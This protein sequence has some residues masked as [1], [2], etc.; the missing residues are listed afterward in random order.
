MKFRGFAF[1]GAAFI[2]LGAIWAV[3]AVS[4]STPSTTSVLTIKVKSTA[5]NPGD[6][7]VQDTSGNVLATCQGPSSPGTSK[8]KVDVT[9]GEGILLVAQPVTAGTFMHWT[10]ACSSVPGP[11]CHEAVTQ[12]LTAVGHFTSTSSTPSAVTT[13]T[14]VEGDTTGCSGFN[15]GV[16]VNGTGFPATTSVTLSD[17]GLQVASGTTDGS[18]SAQ[19]SFTANSESGI[20]RTLVMAT[21]GSAATTDIYNEGSYCLDQQNGTGT[22][23]VS[24]EVVATDLDANGSGTIRFANKPLLP[25]Q[26]NASGTYTVTTPGYSC[27]PG[28]SKNLV[29]KNVRGS[30]S[31]FSFTDVVTFGVTC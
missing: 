17:D 3:P 12:N 2:V 23:T 21:S 5:A 11:I 26:A 30:G 28:A 16:T 18:G 9:T 15:D 14:F 6:I 24:F 22:G 19:L 25:T 13:T 31:P 20:Y 27:P 7:Q 4:A 10:A 29:I 1:I 8:C